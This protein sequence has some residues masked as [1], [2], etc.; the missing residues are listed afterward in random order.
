MFTILRNLNLASF[1]KASAYLV[2]IFPKRDD[3]L[4]DAMISRQTV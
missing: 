4:Y 2:K 1:N 3:K